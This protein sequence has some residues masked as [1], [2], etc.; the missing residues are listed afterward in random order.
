VRSADITGLLGGLIDLLYP[1]HCAGCGRPVENESGHV[2]WDCRAGADFV[3]APFCDVCGDPVEGAVDH[4]FVC[5]ACRR[6][7]PGFDV[8]RSALRYRGAFRCVIHEMKYNR[9]TA[10]AG[11]LA[12]FLYHCVGIQYHNKRFDVVTCVPLHASREKE[13]TYNQSDLLARSLASRLGIPAASRCVSRV[14]PTIS[15]SGLKANERRRNVRN[16]FAVRDPGWIEG[17]RVLL[18]DDV[19]TTGSTVSECARALKNSRAA[20]VAVVTVARG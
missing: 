17:R 5:S 11:E 20:Y 15:Q 6:R 9:H 3:E 19:M 1:R 16:A 10:L 14:H 4:R 7:P 2:C 8:A 12:D 13:R 18:V